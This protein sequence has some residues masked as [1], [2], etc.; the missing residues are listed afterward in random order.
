MTQPSQDIQRLPELPDPAERRRLREAAGLSVIELAR[1]MGVAHIT[2]SRWENGQDPKS[3]VY[4][5]L[6]SDA[7][8]QLA[9]MEET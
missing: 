5:R 1:Q 9:A 8:N 7:L 3:G 2:V 4:R 6:Y